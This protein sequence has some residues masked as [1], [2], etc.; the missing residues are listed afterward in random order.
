MKHHLALIV[1]LLMLTAGLA[2]ACGGGN[3]A[4]G[5]GATPGRT[6]SPAPTE[7]GAGSTPTQDGVESTP[8]QGGAESTPTR[9]EALRDALRN[10]LDAIGV[11][12][13]AVPG[14]VRDQILASCRELEAFAE[15]ER[16]E[17]ICGAI[18]Q[19]MER[20]DPGLIDL[21]LNQLAELEP[22]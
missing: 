1:A 11:N 12:I 5:N 14:D 8:T 21:V 13:G 6:A 7:D 17:E 16:V 20:G 9:F 2:G 3:G 22:D 10:Q 19:A 15:G 18:E 4:G